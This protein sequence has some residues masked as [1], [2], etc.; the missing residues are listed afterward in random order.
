MPSHISLCRFGI[1][2][3]RHDVFSTLEGADDVTT[4]DLHA[5]NGIVRETGFEVIEVALIIVIS[6]ASE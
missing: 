5:H 2:I 4:G 6:H 1:A 3:E